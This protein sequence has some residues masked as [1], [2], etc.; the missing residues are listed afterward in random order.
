MQQLNVVSLLWRFYRIVHHLWHVDWKSPA[1]K[2]SNLEYS[3]FR[4]H[5][6]NQLC[7]CQN[8]L[9]LRL[10]SMFIATSWQ[11]SI[12]GIVITIK[13]HRWTFHIPLHLKYNS[14]CWRQFTLLSEVTACWI[15]DWCTHMGESSLR[16]CQEYLLNY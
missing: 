5:I 9:E 14:F 15:T 7:R 4:F 3:Q 13:C 10:S 16:G 1:R 11:T 8:G 12:C 2:I 6:S